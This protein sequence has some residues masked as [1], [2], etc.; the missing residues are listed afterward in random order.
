MAYVLSFWNKADRKKTT[1]V[2]SGKMQNGMFKGSRIS[3]VGSD[4]ALPGECITKS[5]DRDCDRIERI[6]T[7]GKYFSKELSDQVLIHVIKF[8][9]KSE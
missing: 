3:V 7:R 5:L 9:V 1:L 8:N 4:E 2:S 6:N